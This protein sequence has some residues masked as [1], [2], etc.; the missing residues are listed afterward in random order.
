MC[1]GFNNVNCDNSISDNF[2][3][4]HWCAMA[5]SE[6][7]KRN[8]DDTKNDY[9]DWCGE[10]LSTETCM[11]CNKRFCGIANPG[12]WWRSSK[13]RHAMEC[14]DCDHVS[15]NH[16]STID[17]CRFC[18]RIFCNECVLQ[19][20]CSECKSL[21]HHCAACDPQDCAGGYCNGE[22]SE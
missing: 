8:D 17:Y 20:E 18:M 12:F 15:C 7:R 3:S 19:E 9:C 13:C 14:C 5:E 11:D 21:F 22:E 4:H 2:Y 6:K 1:H 10:D 16:C